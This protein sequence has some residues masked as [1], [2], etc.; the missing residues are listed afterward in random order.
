MYEHLADLFGG[1]PNDAHLTLYRRWAESRWGMIITGNVQVCPKHLTLGADMV[2]PNVLS[3]ESLTPWKTLANA[4]KG[5]TK[6]MN[7][8]RSLA[9]MQLSHAGRQ[10]TNFVGGRTPFAPPSAPSAVPL[11]NSSKHGWISRTLYR[12][13]FQTPRSMSKSE[14]EEVVNR[15]VRGAV[16]A[17]ESG[18]DGVQLHA[19]HGCAYMFMSV[20]LS[21]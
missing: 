16:L 21:L 15:F 10:S 3:E 12:I 7:G 19:A 4:M 20:F 9:I 5:E 2:I 8:N 14:I 13:L 17:N 6:A 1:A 11:G 18:F